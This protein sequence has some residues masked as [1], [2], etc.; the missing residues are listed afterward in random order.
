MRQA[1]EL[2]EL[3][4]GVRNWLIV[5]LFNN[6]EKGRRSNRQDGAAINPPAALLQSTIAPRERELSV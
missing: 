5:L 3:V 6:G 2:L 4:P 1:A